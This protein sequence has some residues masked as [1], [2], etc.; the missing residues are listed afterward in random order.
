MAASTDAIMSTFPNTTI[1]PTHAPGE[2][3]THASLNASFAMLHANAASVPSSGGDGRLGYL[4]ITLGATAYM[5]IS[6]NHVDYPPP[7]PPA[8]APDLP[9]QAT[10]AL[11][12]ELRQQFNDEKKEYKMWY[13]VDATLR[14][15]LLN[16]TDDRFVSGL[17]H[18]IHGYALVTVKALMD[19]LRGN[20]GH[21]TAE[22]LAQNDEDMRQ[23]WSPS[24]PIEHLY[25]QIDDGQAF[26][27]AGA[28]PYTDPQLVRFAYTIISASGLMELACRDWRAKPEADKTWANFKVDMKL[29]HLD[30]RLAP[31]SGSAG[32]RANHGAANTDAATND[33]A[34]AAAGANEA[35]LANLTEAT[36][37][38]NAQVTALSATIAQ[39]QQQLM[40]ATTAIAAV[41][42]N[43]QSNRR[44]NRRQQDDA[45]QQTGDAAPNRYCWTH[46]GRSHPGTA[47]RSP[48]EG[49]RPEA[50]ITNRLGGS[51]R[52][53]RPAGN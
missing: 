5:A 28:A 25:T 46:G 41:Q 47:C 42:Q 34:A 9:A 51:N 29:A 26:A 33:D 7:I 11:I 12:S 45:G 50:T 24:A 39:L 4:R 44:S 20:H 52:Y 30:L 19:F 3:P 35:Y 53:C 40:T 1:L 10:A 49:H 36:I 21:I 15:Q 38:N 27:T 22:M 13:L 32:Y 23:D 48:G 43:Q 18:P 8:A 6:Q 37:A 17:K 2:E 14:Q 16:A 31:T